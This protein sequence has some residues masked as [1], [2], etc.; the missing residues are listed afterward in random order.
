M[1][2][3]LWR[4]LCLPYLPSIPLCSTWAESATRREAFLEDCHLHC[5]E[6]DIDDLD[7]DLIITMTMIIS[8]GV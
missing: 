1:T 6:V 5:N 4:C 8:G 2:F 7:Y 3:R